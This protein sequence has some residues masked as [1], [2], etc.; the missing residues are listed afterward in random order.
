MCDAMWK[1]TKLTIS[2]PLLVPCGGILT[3]CT[4]R[5]DRIRWMILKLNALI[6]QKNN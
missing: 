6:V 2:C 4:M 1:K 3:L 5:G